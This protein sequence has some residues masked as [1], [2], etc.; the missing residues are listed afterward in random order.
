MRLFS[1]LVL[2]ISFAVLVVVPTA[3]ASGPFWP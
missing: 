3:S 2:C 1:A